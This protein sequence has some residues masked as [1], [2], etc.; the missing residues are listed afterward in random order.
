MCIGSGL[1]QRYI[2][3]FILERYLS[4]EAMPVPSNKDT[5]LRTWNRLWPFSD[6]YINAEGI[7]ETLKKFSFFVPEL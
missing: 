2:D 4:Y 3:I 1:Y 7:S 5:I 6:Y